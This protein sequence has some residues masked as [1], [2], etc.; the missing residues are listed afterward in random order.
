MKLSLEEKGAARAGISFPQR[1]LVAIE[2]TI[3]YYALLLTLLFFG[4][5]LTLL[6]V[7]LLQRLNLIAPQATQPANAHG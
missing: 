4:T 3:W 7:V 6:V 2:W 1:V 5:L